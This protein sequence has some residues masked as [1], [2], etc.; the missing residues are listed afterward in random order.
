MNDTEKIEAIKK[1]IEC[2]ETWNP[3]SDYIPTRIMKLFMD[4]LTVILEK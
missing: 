1:M 3:Y 4:N 2:S